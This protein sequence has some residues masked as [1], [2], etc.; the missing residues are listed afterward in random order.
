VKKPAEAERNRT[1]S[2][3]LFSNPP[4]RLGI[5]ANLPQFSLLILINAFVG[6]MVGLERTVLPLIAEQ[7]FG[8]VSK[9][10]I[11]SFLV[12]FGIVKALSNLLAG[13]FSEQFGRRKILIIGWLF[14]IPVP[15]LLIYASTWGWV[16]FANLLLGVNQGLCWSATV[17]MKIDLAGPKRRGL[18][19]GLNEFSGYLAVAV[20]AYLSGYLA[21][22]HGLRPYPFYLGIGF[23]FLGLLL[24]ITLVK[25]TAPF[26]K[27]ESV[28]MGSRWDGASF[29]ESFGRT[30]W[31]DRGL[32]ACSQAGFVNNLNDGVAWGVFP[33]FFA[34]Q[35]LSIERI[36]ILAGLYPATWGIGQLFTGAVSDRIGRKKMIVAGMWLQGIAILTIALFPSWSPQ[37]G[38]IVFLG[39]GTAMVYPTLLASIGDLSEPHWRATSVGVYRLWRDLGYAIGAILSGLIA[40]RFG[41]SSAI[42]VVGLLTVL[43]GVVVQ[44]KLKKD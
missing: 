17:I 2:A 14:G 44:M 12:G 35:G 39:V 28:Q 7:E 19:M 33:L 42:I 8:I 10:A 43:S 26:A 11:L 15:L 23:S 41:I 25:E 29:K 5:R 30:S 34:A 27:L 3:V 40:D 1:I 21:A 18:A 13:T 22:E 37:V 24:S 9:T 4:L 38:A 20:A 31:K 6:A 32:F 36:G 16:S